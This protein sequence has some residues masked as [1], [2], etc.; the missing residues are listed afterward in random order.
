MSVSIIL[1]TAAMLVVGMA[2]P[3]AAAQ[4]SG[5]NLPLMLKTENNSVNVM[6]NWNPKEIE[7]GNKVDFSI[8]FQQP[9][10]GTPISHVNYNLRIVDES[11]AEVESLIKLH[12][13]TGQDVQTVTFGKTG[14]FKLMIE[15]IGTGLNPPFDTT[16]SGKV[17]AALMVVPEFPVVPAVM[18]VATGLAV[19]AARFGKL[20]LIKGHD[21]QR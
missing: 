2:Y 4:S 16:K 12:T 5:L 9:S 18:A 1:A 3:L 17:E 15:I 6:V 14:D 13:H 21:K 11:G 20:P 19:L 10:T 7:P 8:E